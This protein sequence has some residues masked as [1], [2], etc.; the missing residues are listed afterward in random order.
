MVVVVVVVDQPLHEAAGE[1][2]GLAAGWPGI[3]VVFVVR[4]GFKNGDVRRRG[5]PLCGEWWERSVVE[6]CWGEGFVLRVWC[7]HLV[8]GFGEG[9]E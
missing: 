7:L 4:V 5:R 6:I 1:A 8:L 2:P 9:G 3:R